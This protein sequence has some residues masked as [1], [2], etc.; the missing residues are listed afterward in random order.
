M[1]IQ[2]SLSALSKQHFFK[3]HVLA[4]G[5]YSSTAMKNLQG[6]GLKDLAVTRIHKLSVARYLRL[7]GRAKPERP[8]EKVISKY[9]VVNDQFSARSYRMCCEHN[10]HTSFAVKAEV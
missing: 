8:P 4:L 1:N 3:V 9:F 10:R 5:C 6:Y 7:S 2:R